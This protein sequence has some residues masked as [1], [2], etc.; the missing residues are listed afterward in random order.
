MGRRHLPVAAAACLFLTLPLLAAPRL[1]YS[2]SFPGSSP[3]WVEITIER[4]GAGLYKEDPKDEDPLKFQ[5][6]DADAGQIFALVD[7][8]D[9]FSRPLESGLKVANMG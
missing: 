8:L 9:R 2:K 7:K 4:T 3:A 5:L 6:A 1:T